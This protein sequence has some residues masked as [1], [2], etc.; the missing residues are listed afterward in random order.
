MGSGTG[1]KSGSGSNLG[2]SSGARPKATIDLEAKDVTAE[3]ADTTEQKSLS[4][5]SSPNDRPKTKPNL[6]SAKE[7]E[8]GQSG[9]DEKKDATGTSNKTGAPKRKAEENSGGFGQAMTHLASGVAGGLVALICAAYGLN[10]ASMG[11][12]FADHDQSKFET[13]IAAVEKMVSESGTQNAGVSESELQTVRSALDTAQAKV[14]EVAQNYAELKERLAR[15]E[16]RIPSSS[17]ESA[18]SVDLSG[19]ETR[20]GALET[21]LKAMQDRQA[22]VAEASGIQGGGSAD[23]SALVTR[24]NEKLAVLK[25]DLTDKIDTRSQSAA[26]AQSAIGLDAVK[27]SFAAE[28]KKIQRS[29]SEVREQAGRTEYDLVAVKSRTDLIG[30]EVKTLRNDASKLGASITDLRRDLSAISEKT[31]EVDALSERVTPLSGRVSKLEDDVSGVLSRENSAQ[32]DARKTALAVA[33]ANL[34]RVVDRGD[35][36]GNELDIMEKLAPSGL[37]FDNLKPF[38]T[39]GVVPSAKLER[40][41]EKT[42]RSIIDADVAPN[43]N[44]IVGSLLANARSVVRVRRT[45]DVPGDS[46]EAIVARME[47]R[48]KEGNLSAAL[49]EGR[50]LKGMAHE[51]ADSWLAQV[52]ARLSVDEALKKLETELIAALGGGALI[53][54]ESEKQ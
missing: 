27:D 37:N 3:K 7:V 52:S 22:I 9:G 4:D 29:V 25:Q 33:L 11:G 24:F 39:T 49:K 48:V 43:D 36:Y 8:T 17:T 30:E 1:S 54:A 14:D 28:S 31:K 20:I 38:R 40:E 41:F 32:A 34:K 26:V 19:L 23:I 42:A 18:P 35:G 10:W 51:A 5:Q 47:M 16:L 6:K 53:G 2:G 45:G 21:D 46:T 50:A 15:A 12:P 44:S 13:R